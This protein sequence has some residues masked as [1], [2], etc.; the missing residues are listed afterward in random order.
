MIRVSSS[1]GWWSLYKPD[2]LGLPYPYLSQLKGLRANTPTRP[3]KLPSELLEITT[4]LRSTEWEAQLSAHPDPEFSEF[5]LNGIRNGFR[6][7]FNYHSV[8]L[9]SHHKNFRSAKDQPAVVNSYLQQ[10]L[11]LGR[12][13][14]I[15]NPHALPWVQ[16]NA[17]G[18]IPKRKSGK[19]RLIV[20]LSAPEGHSVNDGI[21]KHLCS[22]SYIS[23]DHI[24]NTVLQLGR[25]SLLAKVD[26]KEAYRNVPVAPEDRLLL[27]MK[28]EDSLYLDK[29]LPFGLRSA[30]ILFTALADALEWM[31]RRHGVQHIF[32]YVDDFIIVGQPRSEECAHAVSTTLNIFSTLGVPVEPDKCEGPSTS[33][34]ILGIEVD[35]DQM[36][37]RLPEEKLANLNYLI[38]TWRGRKNATKRELLSLLG[39]L[40]HAAKVVRPGRA[41]V[42][43]MIDLSK[44][45]K[46]L[47][48]IIRITKEFRSDLE[49]WFQM[50]TAWNGTSILSP[51]KAMNPDGEI[52]SDASGSW[53]CGAFHQDK[54]FQLQWD[55]HSLPLNITGKELLPIIM[56]AAVWGKQWSGKTIRALCDNMAAVH[57]IRSRQ[58]EDAFAMHLMRCLSLLE[59]AFHFSLVSRHIP[60]KHNT[61]ADALSRNNLTYFL[62]NHPQAQPFPTPIPTPLHE[63]LISLRPDWTSQ[64]WADLF[65]S[66]TSRA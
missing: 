61:L 3:P 22:L 55:P 50:A 15:K 2:C 33:L 39:T 41:F 45:R 42:R 46:H 48:A 36:Q 66:I 16:L 1:T 38:R 52:T 25:G 35:T 5:I 30:P 34:T 54:W 13:A 28:W 18:V 65:A 4:P 29:T 9:K 40:Q 64:S 60:G 62:S 57:I 63:A 26:I 27:G 49:W 56:A 7:G 10:E 20:D 58:S 23:V 31:V 21:S 19:W 17:F 6:V 8:K 11:T 59:C 37:L 47:E 32:H 24:A 12:I 51:L 43:R 44:K 14:L 53:G